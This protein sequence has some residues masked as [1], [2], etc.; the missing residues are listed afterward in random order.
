MANLK[1]LTENQEANRV[2]DR[3]RSRRYNNER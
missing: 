3:K 2:V 1:R